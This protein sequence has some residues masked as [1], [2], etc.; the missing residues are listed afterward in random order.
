MKMGLL[1]V[2]ALLA[3]AGTAHAQAVPAPAEEASPAAVIDAQVAAFNR[4]DV[5]AFASFY[6]D[7][8]ELFDLP[9]A[10]PMLSGKPALIARYGPFFAGYR[11]RATILS[12]IVRGGFVID[13]ERTVV[14]DRTIEGA[15]VYQVERGRIRRVWFTP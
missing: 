14:G 1:A 8:V 10:K 7:D 12:R 15:A 9:D 3:S 11:P 4:G 13:D 6:A 2:A 5:A